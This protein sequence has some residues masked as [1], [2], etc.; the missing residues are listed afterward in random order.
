MSDYYN[1]DLTFVQLPC[2]ITDCRKLKVQSWGAYI[3]ITS[4]SKFV[5]IGELVQ[6]LKQGTHMYMNSMLL[7]EPNVAAAVVV[8]AA[9]AG[10]W[11]RLWR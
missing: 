4:T 3:H 9:A 10:Q 1:S 5:K 7:H 11:W 8:V 6:K 2:F